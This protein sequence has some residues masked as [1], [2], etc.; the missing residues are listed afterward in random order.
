MKI[1]GNLEFEDMEVIPIFQ[2]G[3]DFREIYGTWI[4]RKGLAVMERR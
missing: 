3:I 2:C 1:A 4:F